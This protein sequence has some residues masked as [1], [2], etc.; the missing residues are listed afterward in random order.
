MEIEFL[1]HVVSQN[2][3]TVDPKKIEAI[4]NYVLPTTLK[5]L[6]SFLGFSGYYRKFIAGYAQIIK[7]LS[8]HLGNHGKVSKKMSSKIKI[9]FDDAAVDA[10]NLIKQKL[11]EQ[12]ELFQPNYSKPF[13]LTTDA[14]NFAIGAVL[15]Q[16]NK[17]I[18]FISRTLSKAEIKLATNE[19][20]LLAIVWALKTLRNYVYGIADLTI[21]TDH[22]PLTEAVSEKNPNL[23]IK[24]WKA[25]VE[26]SGAKLQYKPGSENIVADALSRQFYHIDDDDDSDSDSDSDSIHSSP[27]SPEPNTIRRVSIPLNFYKS[28]FLI[29]ESIQDDLRTET[30]FP[31]YILHTIRFSHIDTLIRNLEISVG[32]TTLNAIHTTEEIFYRISQLLCRHLPTI[33][34]VFT[35]IRNRNITD[36]NE[37]EFL[38]IKEH[39]RAH[40]NYVENFIQL[41]K[42]YFFPKMKQRIKALVVNCE[43]CK[44]QKF[45]THPKKQVMN[46]TPIPTFVGEYLQIDIFHAG[47]R[48]YYSTIDKFSKFVTLRHT[49]NKLNSH[50]VIEEILQLFSSCKYVMTDNE[51]IF[52]SFPVKSLFKRKK[53]THTLTP[54]RHSTSNA[55]IE[56][57]HRTLI[58][59]GRCLAAQ[60]SLT[61]EDVIM[62][63]VQEYNNSIHSVTQAKPSE[64]FFHPDRYPNI[65][66]LL[67]KAQES[68]LKF[69]NKDRASKT[70]NHGDVVFV[71]NNRRDKRCPPYTKHTVHEDRGMIIITDKGKEIHKDTIRK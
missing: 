16:N 50:E 51:L 26:S 36:P 52:T 13:E 56:R 21:F 12:I 69:Q 37:Q 11:Q 55:Q 47:N 39:E 54:I 38:L 40:R 32:E 4:K 35:T 19:K 2:R 44:M 66:K 67:K 61:F 29:E 64:V 17:P 22:Q 30:I 7:P 48:M 45:D 65:P 8:I 70:F 41:K 3:I 15:S 53:I 6:R 24:R 14:S 57:F 28:Q 58:E 34:F 33:K 10:F 60:H 5:Q 20:E 46:A 25:F 42:Q 27:S 9:Q 43:I 49:E 18:T 23:M 71:K 1:G 31:G 62:D 59:I 63:T 68:M